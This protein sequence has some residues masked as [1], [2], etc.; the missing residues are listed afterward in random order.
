MNYKI[1]K[2]NRSNNKNVKHVQNYFKMQ[3]PYTIQNGCYKIP[4][5]ISI[6]KRKKV[7]KTKINNNLHS[8][9]NKIQS[10]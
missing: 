8:K 5:L 3:N 4:Y 1:H 7:N 6:S 9:R 10:K 2:Q